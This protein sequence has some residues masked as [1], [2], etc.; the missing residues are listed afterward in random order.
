[1]LI[2]GGIFSYPMK[3]P[4]VDHLLGHDAIVNNDALCL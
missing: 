1:M 3:G 4:H 2:E